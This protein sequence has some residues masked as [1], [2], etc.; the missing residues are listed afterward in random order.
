MYAWNTTD[1]RNGSTDGDLGV[2]YRTPVRSIAGGTMIA[3]T[4][5][6]HWRFPSV[7]GGTNDLVAD[8]Y[9]A[10]TGGEKAP[11][12]FS[13]NGKTLVKSDLHRGTFVTLQALYSHRLARWNSTYL[14]L[15]HGPAYIYSWN[16]YARSGHRALR[17]VA[18]AQLSRGSWSIEAMFRPQ[19]GLQPAI[20]D[21][22]FWTI[23][24]GRRFGF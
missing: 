3:G 20:P 19:A 13:A 14:S 23:G 4:G 10:W 24:I 7:L 17:Y 1:L 8:T 12:T 18:S 16:V 21:N 6:E 15:Q 2:R 5:I 22:R 11:V 9:L